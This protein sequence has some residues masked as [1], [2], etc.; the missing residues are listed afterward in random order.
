VNAEYEIWKEHKGMMG[1]TVIL[2]LVNM[3]FS[4]MPLSRCFG[5]RAKMLRMAGVDCSTSA[6]IIATVRI[7]MTNVSIGEDTFIGHQ[8]LITGN[9]DAKISIGNHVDL[10]PRVVVISGT[11]EIDML[12]EHSAGAGFGAAVSIQDGVWIGANCTILP[13]VT[14]GQ[15]SVI[16]SGSVV[17]R[18]I[19]PYCVAVG[20]PC[21]PI[22]RWNHELGIFERLTE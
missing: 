2:Q 7:V 9:E 16:G 1:K 11:H 17:S 10:A 12:G 19:P 20:N 4:V 14:I 8:V 3:L 13:G 22:K 21:R 5:I 18:D 6:R 15:K